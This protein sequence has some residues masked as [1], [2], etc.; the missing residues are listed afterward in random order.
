MAVD[1][2]DAKIGAAIQGD[3]AESCPFIKGNIPDLTI[4]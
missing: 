2:L 4:E 1:A 3:Q